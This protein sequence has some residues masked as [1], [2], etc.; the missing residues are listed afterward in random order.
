MTR[1]EVLNS[2]CSG[3]LQ[4]IGIFPE[5]RFSKGSLVSFWDKSLEGFQALP[6]L[7]VY[8]TE[9]TKDPSP[10]EHRILGT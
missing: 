4:G 7:D 3:G 2:R 9:A 10:A 8:A 1:S 5:W 6:D